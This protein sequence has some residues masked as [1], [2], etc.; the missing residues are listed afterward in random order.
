MPC[1]RQRS[2]CLHLF[3][4]PQNLYLPAYI[5]IIFGQNREPTDYSDKTIKG[6]N[7]LHRKDKRGR[8][9]VLQKERVETHGLHR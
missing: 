4:R 8:S 2:C 5:Y 7:K 3:S 1:V 6:Y 9:K